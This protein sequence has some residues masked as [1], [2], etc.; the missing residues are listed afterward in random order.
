MVSDERELI[1]F[2]VQNMDSAIQKSRADTEYTVYRGIDNDKWMGG[3]GV[4][5]TFTEKAY[6]SFSLDIKKALQ[7]TNSQNPILLQLDVKKGMNVLFIDKTEC[8]MLR[9]RERTYEITELNKNYLI[10]GEGKTIVY[11]IEDLWE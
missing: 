5:G 8:E 11:K 6:G 2:N 4:G 10:D 3:I 1:H 7:Y 9:P